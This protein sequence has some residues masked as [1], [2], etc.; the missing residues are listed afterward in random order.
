[1]LLDVEVSEQTLID[2]LRLDGLPEHVVLE[3]HLTGSHD[4]H[5]KGLRALS[6]KSWHLLLHSWEDHV[7][8]LRGSLDFVEG[9][10]HE[11]VSN[12]VV[13]QVLRVSLENV[14]VRLHLLSM[15]HSSIDS[16]E[17]VVGH[18]VEVVVSSLVDHPGL[19]RH[20][21]HILQKHGYGVPSVQLTM[22]CAILI[23]L[24]ALRADLVCLIVILL[25]IFYFNMNL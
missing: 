16:M 1:M 9:D 6:V 15:H 3:L 22:G 2:E 17:D 25:S 18:V 12:L 11:S 20:E 8:E 7:P 5:V 4:D 24:N 14:G 21:G 23:D 13:G 10:L 19:H